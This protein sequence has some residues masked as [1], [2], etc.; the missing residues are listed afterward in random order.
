MKADD[1]LCL[2][3]EWALLCDKYVHGNNVYA[4]PPMEDEEEN[5]DLEKDEFVVDKLTEI[6]YGGANRKSC[7]YFKVLYCPSDS[8]LFLVLLLF[9][10]L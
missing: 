1:F 2:L 7:I 8:F 10:L 5:G 3:K 9:R 4:D 6:C